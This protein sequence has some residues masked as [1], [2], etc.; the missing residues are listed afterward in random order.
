MTSPFDC[1]GQF[2]FD[3][4]RQQPLAPVDVAIID[5]GVD[6]THSAL[7]GRVT[8]AWQAKRVE[9]VMTAEPRWA[10]GP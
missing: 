2:D 4:L 7:A 6:A 3:V 1:L 5:S 9:G 8:T 10:L